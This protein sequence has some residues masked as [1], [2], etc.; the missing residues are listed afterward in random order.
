VHAGEVDV[1]DVVGR[2]IVADL[3]ARPVDA[4][5]LDRFAVLDGAAGG[6]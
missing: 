1:A 4:F 5:N 6:D 3:P 2:V